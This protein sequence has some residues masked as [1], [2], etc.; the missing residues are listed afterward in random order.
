M[1]V[2]HVLIDLPFGENTKLERPD[3]LEFL[4]REFKELFAKV[5]IKCFTIKRQIK[6]PEGNGVGPALEIR[7]AIRILEQTENRSIPLEDT[8]LDMAEILLENTD[9]AKKGEGRKL[10]KK[11]LEEGLALKKFW[12]IATAQGQKKV[13]KSDEIKIGEFTHEVKSTKEGVIRHI[14][15]R[16]IVDIARALGTPKIK[17]AGIYLNKNV[18]DKINKDDSIATLHSETEE[19]LKQ[20]IEVL[21]L[22]NTWIIS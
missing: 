14:N 18:G 7:E 17:K 2:S 4:E 5:G 15:T 22:E 20:G 8:I 6:G 12:E 3:D 9:K 21:D 11:T 10:A 19:R 13:V 1:Q 16:K